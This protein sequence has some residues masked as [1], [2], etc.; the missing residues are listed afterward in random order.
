M[1]NFQQN[2]LT[3]FKSEQKYKKFQ[4]IFENIREILEI[5]EKL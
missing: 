3:A 1:L 4:N 2:K 5:R